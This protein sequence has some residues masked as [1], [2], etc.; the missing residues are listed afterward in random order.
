MSEE[1][2]FQKQVN[3]EIE[4]FIEANAYSMS[5]C[6]GLDVT[7]GLQKKIL[8]LIEEAKKDCE[9]HSYKVPIENASSPATE[10]YE[11]ICIDYKIWKKW[12]GQD[13]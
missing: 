6:T 10:G 12:F 1:G 4:G 11:R 8:K 9:T 2:K 3:K 7:F 5:P 13:V